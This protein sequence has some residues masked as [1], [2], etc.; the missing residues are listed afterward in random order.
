MRSNNA[1]S[2]GAIRRF[3]LFLLIFLTGC[4]SAPGVDSTPVPSPAAPTATELPV[5][6][7]TVPPTSQPSPTPSPVPS[8]TPF[9]LPTAD[10]NIVACSERKPAP[11]DLLSV[12]T[13]GFGVSEH[14]VPKDLVR[15]DKYLSYTVVYSEQIKVRQVMVEPLVKMIKDMQAAGLKPIIRSGYRGYYDQV[16]SRA[17]W[18]QQNP[19]R[20][21]YVSAMPGHSEHQLGLVVDFGSPEL[22][23]IV[24]DPSVEYHS[25]FDQTSEG[26]WLLENAHR[27]GFTL[28]YPPDAFTWTGLIY[29]PWHYRYIGPELATYLHD[30]GQF[31]T[32]FLMQA[33]PT[34]PCMPGN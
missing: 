1:Q 9:P 28:S 8:P 5:A 19:A 22:P 25:A 6:V 33:R 4:A 14:Y 27:Y 21:G 34:L 30:R 23:A 31:L 26:K 17:K 2:A 7:F 11:D 10:P 12:V 24:G 3:F 32:Q 18:E 16:A 15:L 20:A 13:D 29:E